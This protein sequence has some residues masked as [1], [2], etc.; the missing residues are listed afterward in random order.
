MK[1]VFNRVVTL[2]MSATLLASSGFSGII[3]ELVSAQDNSEKVL[4]K[5]YVSTD[6]PFGSVGERKFFRDQTVPL[7]NMYGT[8]ILFSPVM[9]GSSYFDMGENDLEIAQNPESK[10]QAFLTRNI[11]E[12]NSAFYNE[13]ASYK[14]GLYNGRDKTSSVLNDE[15]RKE[16]TKNNK[17]IINKKYKI[18]EVSYNNIE[19][20]EGNIT[21]KEPQNGE[22]IRLVDVNDVEEVKKNYKTYTS[23]KNSKMKYRDYSYWGNISKNGDGTYKLELK[24]PS[25]YTDYV[26]ENVHRYEYTQNDQGLSVKELS[27]DEF[28]VKDYIGNS[29]K[30]KTLVFENIGN[31][32][33]KDIVFKAKMSYHTDF[34]EIKLKID[35]STVDD[36]DNFKDEL[37]CVNLNSNSYNQYK[38]YTGDKFN[39]IIYQGAN[40]DSTIAIKKLSGH[41]DYDVVRYTLDGT[42]PTNDSKSVYL[43]SN[44][45]AFSVNN[46]NSTT[47]NIEDSR[48]YSGGNRTIK[49]RAFHGDKPSSDVYKLDLN[50]QKKSHYAVEA[51]FKLDKEYN[52]TLGETFTNYP[53]GEVYY[54]TKIKTDKLEIK[55]NTKNALKEKNIGR[56]LPLKISLVDNSGNLAHLP[57][58][59]DDYEPKENPRTYLNVK[60][61]SEK[62]INPIENSSSKDIE[63][64]RIEK[65]GSVTKI[66]SEK[67]GSIKTDKSKKEINLTLGFMKPE[68]KIIIAEP[69]SMGPSSNINKPND[70]D[71][72]EV[73]SELD[74]TIE[75]AKDISLRATKTREAIEK[76]DKAIKKAENISKTGSDTEKNNMNDE[77]LYE[78]AQIKGDKSNI[79]DIADLEKKENLEEG[80]YDVLLNLRMYETPQNSSMGDNAVLPKAKLI[81]DKDGN[82]KLRFNLRG[83]NYMQVNGN[84]T[85][86]WSY[87]TLKDT[88]GYTISKNGV[89]NQED[90]KDLGKLIPAKVISEK[91]SIGLDGKYRKFPKTL[92]ISLSKFKEDPKRYIRIR[93]DAMDELVNINP[94]DGNDDMGGTK[95]AILCIDYRYI[96]KDKT[97]NKNPEYN[98]DDKEPQKPN[99]GDKEK[100][101]ASKAELKSNIDMAEH[102][103][104]EKFITGVSKNYLEAAIKNALSVYNNKD[105]DKNEITLANSLVKFAIMNAK[106]ENSDKNNDEKKNKNDK[107]KIIDEIESKDSKIYSV[108]VK[109]W[110]AYNDRAS[111]GNPAIEKTAI[112]KEKDGKYTY[113]LSF[114]GLN[115]GGVRGHLWDL[116]IFEK[117]LNG[118]V[119]NAKTEKEFTDTDLEGRKRAFPKT[120]SFTRPSKD[121]SV[122]VQV[123][124]DAMDAIASG[125]ATTYNSIIRGK[126]SQNARLLFDWSN[127][128]ESTGENQ[129]ENIEPS[130]RISGS[131]RYETSVNI[132]KKYF[133]KADTVVLASG[134]NSADALVSASYAKLNASPILLTNKNSIESS[135]ESEIERLGAKNI[136][137]VGGT[138]SVSS[139]IENRLANKGY[140]VERIAGANRFETSSLLA[141][142]VSKKAN[143]KKV[144]II[145]GVKDA[146]ALSVSSLA[147]KENAPVFM[148]ESN[149]IRPSIKKK[150]NDMNAEELL[151]IGG[152]GSISNN[153]VE[154]LNV[155]TK[156]RIAGANR[157]ETAIKIANESYPKANL[158]M[159]A[160]GYNAIDALSAGAVTS[161]AK[162][163]ILL[164]EKYRIPNSVKN[165]IDGKATTILGGENTISNIR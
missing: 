60:G 75:K 55:E 5:E 131:N 72:E 119:S 142:K 7:R 66:D 146:D 76:L 82:R 155:A 56:Y 45:V 110:N 122:N 96:S 57:V 115:I 14:F 107:D 101:Q 78:I 53:G 106:N 134:I 58:D 28:T 95:L 150:I 54:D 17:K 10:L 74:K 93:T 81:V 11:I 79:K 105:A 13:D 87:E 43:S 143:S 16:T 163:P 3:S 89:G 162:S 29:K 136:H 113:Y 104:K 30:Y 80:V 49:F 108:P 156:R 92:E 61:I 120:F 31:D 27:G 152:T 47:N 118:K 140:K 19:D 128:K 44:E 50:I 20:D 8:N 91:E 133:K 102:L 103:L 154:Q 97:N 62:S 70:N 151:V 40:N 117:E 129:N 33:K 77:L 109:L 42:E 157:Y 24:V 41:S 21:Y 149:N 94:Y 153:V 123:A 46:V 145:N 25:E 130:D 37:T 69:D 68:E 12:A 35:P 32:L 135:V 51:Q 139:S 84:L 71:D 144:I 1:K 98:N 65:N 39:N 23:Y 165:L 88:V 116:K 9:G 22:E 100:T 73:K 15:Q 48:L 141:A 52:A 160:N 158:Y 18:W 38:D 121:N 6:T 83:I 26:N 114:D 138:G 148:V 36:G 67:D 125:N 137:I 112:V 85:K 126:G 2:A 124:V 111:M 147:T 63:L 4:E 59:W 127:A 132:S 164:V 90:N 159:L 86:L 34:E 64:Y 99:K 161:K